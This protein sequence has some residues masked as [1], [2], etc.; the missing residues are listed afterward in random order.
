[1]FKRGSYVDFNDSIR[2]EQFSKNVENLMKKYTDD[3][4]ITQQILEKQ[5]GK[6]EIINPREEVNYGTKNMTLTHIILLLR[7]MIVEGNEKKPMLSVKEAAN[8]CII[9]QNALIGLGN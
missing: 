2:V 3:K 5:K 9:I 4:Y 1:M 7:K 6:I 8:V